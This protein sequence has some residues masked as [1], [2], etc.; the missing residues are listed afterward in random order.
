[1]VPCPC[2]FGQHPSPHGLCDS[3]AFFEFQGG[4]I[5]SVSLRGL[6]FVIA[7]RNAEAAVLFLDSGRSASQRTALK[8]IATWILSLEDTRLVAV[9]TGHIDIEFEQ[10]TL[11]GSVRGTELVLTVKPLVGN[12]SRSALT[13]ANPWMFGSFPIKTSRKGVAERLQVVAPGLSFGYSNTNANDAYF[14]FRPDQ[15]R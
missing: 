7:E 15:V 1:M 10:T 9:M 2:N 8:R 4:E 6:R 14:Q 13:V 12:D 11:S 5:N 3:L